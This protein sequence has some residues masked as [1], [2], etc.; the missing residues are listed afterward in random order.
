MT[1]KRV[2]RRFAASGPPFGALTIK[3]TAYDH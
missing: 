1:N 2:L 3:V